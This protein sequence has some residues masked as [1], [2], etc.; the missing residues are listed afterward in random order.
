MKTVFTMLVL[1]YI[2]VVLLFM[3]LMQVS[4]EANQYKASYET[5]RSDIE[6]YLRTSKGSIDLAYI[7]KKK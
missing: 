5:A 6:S 7:C 4:I 2:I 3:K 1:T